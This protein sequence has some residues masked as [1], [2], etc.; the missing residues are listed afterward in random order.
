MLQLWPEYFKDC[1][2]LLFV[3]DVSQT[4]QLSASC[5]E[6]YHAL[7]AEALRE[8]PVLIFLNKIDLPCGASRR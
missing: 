1:G 2:L 4:T 6:L 8:T 5:V 3:V 7:G